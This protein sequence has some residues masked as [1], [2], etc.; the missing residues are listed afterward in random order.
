MSDNIK[1]NQEKFNSLKQLNGVLKQFNDETGW[2]AQWL[3]MPTW[4]E[5]VLEVTED[6]ENVQDIVEPAL[7]MRDAALAL[8]EAKLKVIQAIQEKL[9]STG[10]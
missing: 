3:M 9:S 10:K 1:V 2:G 4:A 7:A 5:R 8:E 6:M